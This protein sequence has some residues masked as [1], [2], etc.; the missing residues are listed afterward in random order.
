MYV[1]LIKPLMISTS[2]ELHV[3]NHLSY[4]TCKDVNICKKMNWNL[5]LLKLSTKNI[6]YYCGSHLQ[7]SI[8]GPYRL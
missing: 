2:L 4:K 5:L 7:T 6:K 8:Y 1:L 3:A